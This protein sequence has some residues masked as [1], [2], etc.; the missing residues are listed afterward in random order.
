MEEHIQTLRNEKSKSLLFVTRRTDR[1]YLYE[2]KDL[3][4]S[5]EMLL[6][7]GC[8][9]TFPLAEPAEEERKEGEVMAEILEWIAALLWIALGIYLAKLVIGLEEH[10]N[11]VLKEL[12]DEMND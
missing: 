3:W 2:A 1:R 10:V 6:E 11:K 4:F 12:E 9:A 5:A 7:N 8:E